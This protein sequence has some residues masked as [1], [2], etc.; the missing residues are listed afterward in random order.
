MED[1]SGQSDEIKNNGTFIQKIKK[2]SSDHVFEILWGVAMVGLIIV[3]V[4]ALMYGV[5]PEIKVS[6]AIAG[7]A[8]AGNAI[9][10]NGPVRVGTVLNN[11]TDTLP[12]YD[13]ISRSFDSFIRTLTP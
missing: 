9:A 4:L 10:G 3:I 2:W 12:S 13:N 6:P 5:P 8:I 11:F 7:N 1:A